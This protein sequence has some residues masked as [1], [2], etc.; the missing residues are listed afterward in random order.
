M[1]KRAYVLKV[2]RR[3]YAAVGENRPGVFVYFDDAYR[4]LAGLV[5]M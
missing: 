5:S 2:G 4:W 1:V 3:N